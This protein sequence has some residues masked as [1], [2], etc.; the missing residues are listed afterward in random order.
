MFAVR[1]YGNYILIVR[2][3]WDA[4]GF[5][6]RELSAKFRVETN[7]DMGKLMACVGH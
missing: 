3:V 4:D 5:E 2:K 7:G 1:V 6:D